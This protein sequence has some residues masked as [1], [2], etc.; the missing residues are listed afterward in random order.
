M[1][2]QA[3]LVQ[4]LPAGNIAQVRRVDG[5][6]SRI[7]VSTGPRR[8]PIAGLSSVDGACSRINVSTSRRQGVEG[9]RF[10]I[11]LTESR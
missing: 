9:K 7:N 2:A 8:A 11:D 4:I 1:D 3:S 6:C 10:Q 5:A